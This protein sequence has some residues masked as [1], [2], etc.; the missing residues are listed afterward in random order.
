MAGCRRSL[1][2]LVLSLAVLA[3]G[4]EHAEALRQG[5]QTSYYR[6]LR[7]LADDISRKELAKVLESPA[8]ESTAAV[9]V[10]AGEDEEQ[11]Q[12]WQAAPLVNAIHLKPPVPSEPGQP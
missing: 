10:P 9:T 3:A 2:G 11:A 1:L 5:A 8:Q 6:E 7:Q 12:H 4:C